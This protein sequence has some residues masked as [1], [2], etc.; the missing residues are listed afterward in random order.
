MT[1]DGQNSPQHLPPDTQERY[2]EFLAGTWKQFP[3]KVQEKLEQILTECGN[4]AAELATEALLLLEHEHG[5]TN[6][7]EGK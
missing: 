3:P 6:S 7:Q 2:T 1:A 5:E 4:W